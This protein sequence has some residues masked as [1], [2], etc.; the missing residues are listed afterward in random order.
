MPGRRGYGRRESHEEREQRARRVVEKRPPGLARLLLGE[1]KFLTEQDWT[2]IKMMLPFF[3]EFK[4]RFVLAFGCLA[5]IHVAQ[6]AVPYLLKL[7]IDD[8]DS[9][10]A[11]IVALPLALL[12]VYVLVRF[13]SGALR[14]LR[15]AVFGTVTVRAMRRLSLTLLDHLLGLDLEYHVARRTGAVSRDMDRGVMAIT[16]LMRILTFQLLGMFIG[17]FGVAGIMIA[18]FDWIYAAIVLAAAV[19]YGMYT[20]KATAWRTPFIRQ[21]N[22]ANSRANTRA[23]DSLINYETV[24]TFGNEGMETTFYDEDLAIWEKARARNRYSLA[25]LNVGQSFIVH[26]GLLGMMVIAAT[27]VVDGSIGIGDLVAINGYAVQVFVPLNALGSIYR[28]LKNA[29]TDVELMFEIL[30]TS[31]KVVSPRRARG[32]PMGEGPVEFDNVSFAYQPE[33]PI[34]DGIDFRIEPKQTLAL[35]GPSGSGKST[36]ARLLFRFYDPD[37]GTVRVNGTD[38][39]DVDVASL[40]QAFGVVP[41]D[42]TLFNDSLFHNIAYGRLDAHDSEVE[43]AASLARLDELIGRLPNGF[44]TVVGERGLKLSGGE[45]QRVAIARAILKNPTFLIFDEATSSLDTV[46]ERAIMHAI[47]EVSARHT[48]LI[49]SHRLSTVVDADCILLLENG[50]I[51]E[52]GSHTDLLAQGGKYAR[53]WAVQRKERTA[54][55]AT[56]EGSRQSA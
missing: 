12:I 30:E 46:T 18:F 47:E 26:I 38:I 45:K 51:L 43:R 39:R 50:E 3:L 11:Q 2:A 52:T 49:I 25:A 53:M 34:V 55:H 17:V 21:S 1:Q 35:V 31:P 36:I 48:T 56:D 22:E 27:A 40:R 16:S 10:T 14:E 42:V 44:D 19:F 28:Q 13:L 15:E 54:A 9:A 7:I 29:F 8:L 5:V 24:K 20:V 37:R 23:I 41:Q 33:R 4:G 32:L 6:L